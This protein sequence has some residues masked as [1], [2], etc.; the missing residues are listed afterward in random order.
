MHADRD[1]SIGGMVLDSA[2]TSLKKVAEDLCKTYAT[3]MPN[4]L[5]SGALSLI[6]STVQKKANFDIN[7]LSPIDHVKE[8]FIPALFAA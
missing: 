4:F 2:F 7:N 1:P 5:I 8:G 6:R 3:K